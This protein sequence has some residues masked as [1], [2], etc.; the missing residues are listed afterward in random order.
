MLPKLDPV[1]PLLISGDLD[2]VRGLKTIHQFYAL[3]KKFKPLI[4]EESK[5]LIINSL[6][7]D[8]LKEEAIVSISELDEDD[9]LM[10]L[11]MAIGFCKLQYELSRSKSVDECY[12]EIDSQNQDRAE[13]FRY[14]SEAWNHYFKLL[15]KFIDMH[16]W[17]LYSDTVGF[18]YHVVMVKNQPRLHVVEFK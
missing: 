12:T 3:V 10:D 7:I 2:K 15:N 4:D 13:V 18:D 16:I 5:Q 6:T 8:P 1:D 11:V 17:L 14:T 9:E